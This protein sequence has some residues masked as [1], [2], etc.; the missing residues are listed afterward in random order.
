MHSH[1]VYNTSDSRIKENQQILDS[2]ITY[3]IVKQTDIKTYDRHGD[4][5]YSRVGIIAQELK[6]ALINN[7]VDINNVIHISDTNTHGYPFY[8]KDENGLDTEEPL[9]EEYKN[10]T[11]F[12]SISYQRLSV[13]LWG[14]VKHL[15]NKIEELETR[16]A[17]AGI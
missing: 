13:F 12:H 15:G 6:Q 10:I 17:N 9:H 1:N 11:D 5:N 3:N 14:A 8:K 7:N 4:D 16:L 2:E